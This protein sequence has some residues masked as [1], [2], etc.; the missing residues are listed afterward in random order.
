MRE[1]AF[2][3]WLKPLSSEGEKEEEMIYNELMGLFHVQGEEVFRK[4]TIDTQHTVSLLMLKGELSLQM[5]EGRMAIQAPAYIEFIEPHQWTD[6]KTDAQFEGCLLITRRELFLQAAECIRP[7]VTPYIYRYVQAPFLTLKEDDIS[8]IRV[9]FDILWHTLA[10]TENN[11]QHEILENTLRSL[12]L[13]IWNIIFR[14]YKQESEEE[15]VLPW[16]D[17]LPRFLYLMHTHCRFHHTVKWYADQLCVSPD[18]LS[19]KLR[20][21]YRKSANQLINESLMEEAK[22]CLLNPAYTVQDVAEKLCFADQAAFSKFFKR[23]SGMSPGRFKKQ[24]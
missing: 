7:R 14:T 8:R 10:Q 24:L 23:H 9:L 19:A 5:P 2:T 20:K 16:D 6:L 13:E 12:V 1:Y 22:I 3:K 11:F 15:P 17:T 21:A 4:G 18:A